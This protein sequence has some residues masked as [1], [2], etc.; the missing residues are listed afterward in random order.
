MQVAAQINGVSTP[1]FCG[2]TT[3]LG[4]WKQ[5]L[6]GLNVHSAAGYVAKQGQM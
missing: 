3:D 5:A 6:L 2:E 1:I 4:G